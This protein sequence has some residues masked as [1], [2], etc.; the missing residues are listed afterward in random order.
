[1]AGK[2]RR[3][4]GAGGGARRAV[5][6]SCWICGI[7]LQASKMVPDGGEWCDDIR[8]YCVDIT[9]CTQRWM[10]SRSVLSAGD[11]EEPRGTAPDILPRAGAA[12][13]KAPARLAGLDWIYRTW[14]PGG[15]VI[16]GE[17]SVQRI[18]DLYG[19]LQ[20]LSR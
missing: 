11:D 7:R 3:P 16:I 20:N 12:A 9:G 5:I 19:V 2:T 15:V 6:V 18:V 10:T 8:W 14:W 17:P 13:N 1:M 4:P